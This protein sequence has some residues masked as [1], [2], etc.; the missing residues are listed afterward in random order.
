MN[1]AFKIALISIIVAA[2][3]SFWWKFSEDP[4]TELFCG[5]SWHRI[6]AVISMVIGVAIAAI[7][8]IVGIVIGG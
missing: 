3:A 1:W 2:V 7:F 6:T 4:L 8:G 5:P